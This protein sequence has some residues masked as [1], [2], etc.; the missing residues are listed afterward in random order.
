MLNFHDYKRLSRPSKSL[1]TRYFASFIQNI[2]ESKNPY[3]VT[4]KLLYAEDGSKS[5]LTKKHNLNKLFYKKR[6]GEVI[7]RE[8]VVRNIEQKLQKQLHVEI[9]LMYSTICH[10]IWQLLD[11][12]YTEANI[13]SILLS[14]PPAIS[15]KG[16]ARTTSGN[17]KRKHPYGK[18][19][20]ALSEQD[21]LD[22]LTYLLIL[23]Y[24]KVHN[25]EY[26][27]LCT[28]LISTTKMFMR[29][30]MTLPLSPIAADLYY[31][32]A[33]WLNA[34]ESDNESFYLVPMGF[35]SKQ[36]IDF[37]GAIQ[38]YH[39]WLQLALEIGLIE[40]TYHHKMAF[41]KSIDHSL[42][43]KL[44]EDLQDMH[45]YQIG[46]TSYLEKILKRMSYYLA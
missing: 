24:E 31:R 22:A 46:T 35:Y 37:D 21:S 39:Y 15:S 4:K 2:T 5:A 32:I 36:A 8:G 28:E 10:P 33:N 13:N 42:A 3:Q 45:D 14:L 26:A 29:M 34:D 19:V 7:G 17:I 44:T 9:D 11:T 38:C 12:P 25:P 1:A 18:T 6:D 30:A 43:G 23:T 20:H 40:D 16:I 41:L 27:S